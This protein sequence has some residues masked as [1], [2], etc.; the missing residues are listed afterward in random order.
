MK[1]ELLKGFY[2]YYFYEYDDIKNLI[3]S[4]YKSFGAEIFNILAKNSFKKFSDRFDYGNLLYAINIDNKKIDDFSHTAI[5]TR[6][7][8]SKNIK[9]YFKLKANN[10]V[11]YAGKDLE[12]KLKNSRDFIYSGKNGINAILVDDVVTTA[13]TIKEAKSTLT[14]AGVSTLFAISLTYAGEF[15]EDRNY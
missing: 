6:A 15:Y 10:I 11:K 3:Y 5:L 12:F 9:P 13:S 14:R 1:K 4:K 8:K 2:L 7:L